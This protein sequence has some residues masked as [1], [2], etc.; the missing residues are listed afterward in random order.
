MSEQTKDQPIVFA[1]QQA[2]EEAVLKIIEE[3]LVIRLDKK[4]QMYD[5]STTNIFTLEI[6]SDDDSHK[7]TP[8]SQVE[9][10][11]KD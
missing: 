1:N 5:P 11:T 3:R 7:S 2:F 10:Y 8:F 4:N 9:L 6:K